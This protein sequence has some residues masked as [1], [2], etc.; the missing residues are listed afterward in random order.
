V[1]YNVREPASSPHPAP[2]ESLQ[3]AACP[4]STA[5]GRAA[6]VRGPHRR[7][8][9]GS[10]LRNIFGRG[11]SC[12]PLNAPHTRPFTLGSK[13]IQYVVLRQFVGIPL[14]AELHDAP[15]SRL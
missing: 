6:V 4:R 13:T 15:P 12:V 10:R 1:A 11:R 7:V 3:P 2:G 9:L 14:V 8:C 5:P